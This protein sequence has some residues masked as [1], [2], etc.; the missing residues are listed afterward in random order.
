MLYLVNINIYYF[1]LPSLGCSAPH[2]S[3]PNN[4]THVG[5]TPL[6]LSLLPS[7]FHRFRLQC[8]FVRIPPPLSFSFSFLFLQSHISYLRS[9][10]R[11]RAINIYLPLPSSTAR[12][13]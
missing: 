2:S 7:P 1:F 13:G 9:D 10:L 12:V 4:G 8:P 11:E 3:S 6:L 5:T